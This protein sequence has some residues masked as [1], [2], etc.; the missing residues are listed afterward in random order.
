MRRSAHTR[1]S[2]LIEALV[3]SSVLTVGAAAAASMLTLSSTTARSSAL[4]A[5]GV[6]LAEQ[7]LEDLRSLVYASILTR[8]SYTT[9]SPDVFN[10][11][12]FTVHSDVQADQPAA[13]MKTVVVTVGWSDHGA[14]HT[15]DIQTIY[16][17][18]SG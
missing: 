1:G 6:A 17:N 18:I 14:P 15:Y 5:H 10:G 9:S 13:N 16:A 3:A 12:S 8:D 11:T 4:A 2:S 7:E